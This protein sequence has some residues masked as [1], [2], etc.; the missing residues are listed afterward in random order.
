MSIK[1][2]SRGGDPKKAAKKAAEKRKKTIAKAAKAAGAKRVDKTLKSD[3]GGVQ[4]KKDGAT[5]RPAQGSEK[6]VKTKKVYSVSRPAPKSAEEGVGA[7]IYG[8]VTEGTKKDVKKA[9]RKDIRKKLEDKGAVKVTKIS[10]LK[11][12]GAKKKKH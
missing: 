6:K 9:F 10:T 5:R 4:K 12:G 7:G 8:R 11:K 3:I 1:I 2:V